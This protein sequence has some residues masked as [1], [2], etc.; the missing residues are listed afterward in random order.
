MRVAVILPAAGLGTRM[1]RGTAPAAESVGTS[2]KQ[3]ML[4]DGAPILVHTVRKFAASPLVTDIVVAVREED[5]AWVEGLLEKECRGVHAG[6][7]RLS[8]ARSKA[9]SPGEVSSMGGS[10]M[11]SA[12]DAAPGQ[13]TPARHVAAGWR[14]RSAD[15]AAAAR[16][17][18]GVLDMV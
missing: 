5:M 12:P 1:L 14:C 16:P 6:A 2:R 4:F 10:A 3:F 8:Q 15:L 9:H 17:A 13:A 18:G 7:G 11:R